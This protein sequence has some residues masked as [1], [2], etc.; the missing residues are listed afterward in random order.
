MKIKGVEIGDKF[1]KRGDKQRRI[2]TVSDIYTV[3]DS[4]GEIVKHIC[5]ASYEFCN[6]L[7][8][9]EIPFTTVVLGKIN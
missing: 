9:I 4:R 5:I 6:Q 2:H 7:I 3:T 1:I 8:T